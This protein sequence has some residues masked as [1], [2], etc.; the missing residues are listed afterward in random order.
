MADV[1]FSALRSHSPR[2]A[3]SETAYAHLVKK[4]VASMGLNPTIYGTHSLRRSRAAYVYQQTHNL[5]ACQLILGHAS[6]TMTQTYLGVEEA[7]TLEIAR[8]YQM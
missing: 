7:E 1:L 5:R 6:I 8:R 3:L 2:K 4:W